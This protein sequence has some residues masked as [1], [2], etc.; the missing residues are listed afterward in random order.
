MIA[1]PD[2]YLQLELD[3]ISRLGTRQAQLAPV[4][5]QEHT[6]KVNRHHVYLFWRRVEDG[7]RKR[8]EE[9]RVGERLCVFSVF[10]FIK[11]EG[12]EGQEGSIFLVCL[13]AKD[14]NEHTLCKDQL[15]RFYTA[16]NFPLLSTVNQTSKSTD[17]L[18]VDR[19]TK[20]H[21]AH[22]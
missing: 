3:I 1:K 14:P 13:Q 21:K 4:D 20:A 17:L 12:Q 18:L 8:E 10:L 6:M 15:P 16:P 19:G 11:L 5:A 9:A 2:S 7:V 22:E